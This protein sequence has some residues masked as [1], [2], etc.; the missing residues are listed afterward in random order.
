MIFA[1]DELSGTTRILKP[2]VS[3]YNLII[4]SLAA[5]V[6]LTLVF[7][8][9]EGW[10]AFFLILFGAIWN[11]FCDFK[12]WISLI[13]SVFVGVLYAHFAFTSGLYAHALLYLV[14]YVVMQ[15]SVCLTKFNQVDT[16]INRDKRLS[17]TQIYYIVLVSIYVLV[18]GSIIMSGLDSQVFAVMDVISALMLGIS[19]Y[20]RNYRYKEYFAI[21]YIAI[22]TALIL[23]V[24]VISTYGV[25][26]G[27][28]AVCVLY[29]M[30]LLSDIFGY[31]AWKKSYEWTVPVVIS[32]EELEI[33]KKKK[34]KRNQKKK[35]LHANDVNMVQ[36]KKKRR[37]EN[38][39]Q[40]FA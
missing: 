2:G 5:A 28:L 21:R 40:I 24:F 20:L 17:G 30:Y 38:D 29:V 33:E 10:P 8:G 27:C 25:A 3:A 39:P 32:A 18:F 4:S 19:A 12:K 14:Y 37:S 23:W 16:D 15:F 7:A 34:E 1:K 26:N 13:F 9:F 36:S 31:K 11:F 22:I 6:G 35:Q